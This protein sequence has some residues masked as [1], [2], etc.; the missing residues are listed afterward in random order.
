[1]VR[2]L[3][4]RVGV[5]RVRATADVRVKWPDRGGGALLAERRG[6]VGVRGRGASLSLPPMLSRRDAIGRG[7]VCCHWRAMGGLGRGA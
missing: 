1:M 7:V 5:R 4:R 2:L 6:D 3:A